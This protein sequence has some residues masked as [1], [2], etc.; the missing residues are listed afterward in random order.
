MVNVWVFR[1]ASIG[2]LGVVLSI[3]LQFPLYATVG[4]PSV[5]DGAAYAAHLADI[6]VIAF[7]RILLDQGLFVA[8]M[9]FGACF[10]QLVRQARPEYGWLGTLSFGAA[11]VWLAVTLVADGLAGGA[12]LDAISADPDSS[13]VRALIMGT[14]LIYNSSTAFVMT[15]LFLGAAGAA[16]LVSQILPGWTGWLGV[17]G[18]VLCG[19]A[20][21][22]MYGGPVDYA[23]PYNAGSLGPAIIANFVP[24]IWFGVVGV[25]LW[26]GAD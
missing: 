18:A 2:A 21:P 23:G 16:I 13:V 4:A 22:A 8:M 26:R 14:L 7:T 1:W 17:L 9:V 24:I 20:V 25:L 19:L 15:G 6:Q 3:L 5:Y 12:V 10:A 11:V